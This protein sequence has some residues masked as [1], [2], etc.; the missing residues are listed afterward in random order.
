MLALGRRK[1]A[2]PAWKVRGQLCCQI[3]AQKS[4]RRP[5][6]RCPRELGFWCLLME[7]WWQQDP[8][9][10]SQGQESR[11]GPCWQPV[12]TLSLLFGVPIPPPPS[13]SLCYR[14]GDLGRGLPRPLYTLTTL[15]GSP[16]GPGEW[17]EEGLGGESGVLLAHGL[18]PKGINVE[19]GP[20]DS[21]TR[22]PLP[23]GSC[24]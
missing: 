4:E 20:A 17:R 8:S 3:R 13:T 21:S 24:L 15:P 2:G 11:S 18:E 6:Q 5:E 12:L 16:P 9:S 7:P 22:R 23:L 10:L 19:L 14:D 1:P